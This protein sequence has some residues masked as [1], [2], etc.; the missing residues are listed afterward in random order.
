MH[1]YENADALAPPLAL[2]IVCQTIERADN[3]KSKKL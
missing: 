3:R 2:S 1:V